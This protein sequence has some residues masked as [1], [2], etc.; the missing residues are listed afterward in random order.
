MEPLVRDGRDA[1]QGG[2]LVAVPSSFAL[3][4]DV[5]R[6]AGNPPI[7]RLTVV[8]AWSVK[9]KVADLTPSMSVIVARISVPFGLPQPTLRGSA[10]RVRSPADGPLVIVGPGL[11][12]TLTVRASAPDVGERVIF[13]RALVSVAP[14]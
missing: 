14:T 6:L 12:Q 7:G 11:A 1:E 10:Y 2:R 5:Q 3:M 13:G 8:P 4:N 9:I